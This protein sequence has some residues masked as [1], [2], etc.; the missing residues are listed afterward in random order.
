MPRYQYQGE[1]RLHETPLGVLPGVTTVLG[2][3][4]CQTS[5]KAIANWREEVGETEADRIRQE[6]CDRGTAIHKAIEQYLSNQTITIKDEYM[7]LFGKFLPLLDDIQD[8]K[9]I[10][11]DTYHPSGYGGTVDLQASYKK[12]LTI[13][14][15][16]T[17]R[18][19]KK[20]AY[21]KD[22]ILQ[23]CAYIQ[24]L[25]WQY[26]LNIEQ[27]IIAIAVVPNEEVELAEKDKF[28]IFKITPQQYQ[29][30]LFEFDARLK[31]YQLIYPFA[32]F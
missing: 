11:K 14:D 6:S 31:L 8:V 9:F 26:G 2:E 13:F 24:A 17:S 20:R 27:G 19:P 18:K 25:N 23:I 12:T 29:R 10:E 4:K 5:I 21:I 30:D 1:R 28:Q 15:W 32:D 3:T 16:K 7:E 22:Y